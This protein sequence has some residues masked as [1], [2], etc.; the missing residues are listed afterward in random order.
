MSDEKDRINTA[1]L[2]ALAA[3]AHGESMP[4]R[5]IEMP[6]RDPAREQKIA[7]L[8]QKYLAGELS[9]D[10]KAIAAKLVDSLFDTP[11]DWAR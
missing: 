8:K 9:V 1:D 11:P 10:E 5:V 6:A 4:R 3:A 7:E 2:T